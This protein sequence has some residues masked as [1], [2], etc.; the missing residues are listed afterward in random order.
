MS[1]LPA[2]TVWTAVAATTG[3][4]ITGS[5]SLWGVF[6]QLKQRDRLANQRERETYVASI[7]RDRD[8]FKALWEEA[9]RETERMREENRKLAD[10]N[11]DLEDRLRRR[12]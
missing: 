4:I 5:L 12:E 7:E 2:A 9:R 8:Q 1:E 10:R 6:A 11:D 3:S